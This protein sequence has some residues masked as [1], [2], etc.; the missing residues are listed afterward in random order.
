MRSFCHPGRL[1][2]VATSHVPFLICIKGSFDYDSP[3]TTECPSHQQRCSWFTRVHSAPKS[4]WNSPQEKKLGSP[5]LEA[6]GVV[7][8]L[9]RFGSFL[10]EKAVNKRL[11]Q[12]LAQSKETM[13]K[14][15]GIEVSQMFYQNS[16]EPDRGL[17]QELYL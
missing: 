5:S 6:A 10:A 11:M 13:L 8:V 9:V 15:S 3:K 17:K 1:F 2:I 4:T 14:L 12:A 7:L 16:N